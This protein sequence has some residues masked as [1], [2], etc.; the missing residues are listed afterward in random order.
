M[1]SEQWQQLPPQHRRWFYVHTFSIL[2]IVA[3]KSENGAT[4]SCLC[5]IMHSIIERCREHWRQLASTRA[6][7]AHGTIRFESLRATKDLVTII[8]MIIIFRMRTLNERTRH[9]DNTILARAHTHWER[10]A[11]SSAVRANGMSPHNTHRSW[12]QCIANCKTCMPYLCSC[13]HEEMNC[14]SVCTVPRK[15]L[16][17]PFSCELR[18]PFENE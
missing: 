2:K 17:F 1:C 18:R 15:L 13:S 10:G 4:A 7:C 9:R 3:T 8:I 16:S 14:R 11:A 5:R 12:I 6:F